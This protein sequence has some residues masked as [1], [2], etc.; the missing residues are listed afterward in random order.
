MRRVVECGAF[1]LKAMRR[2]PRSRSAGGSLAGAQNL[3]I[4]LLVVLII[5]TSANL[6]LDHFSPGAKPAA[7]VKPPAETSQAARTA[8]VETPPARDTVK[9]AQAST[10]IPAVNLPA[11]VPLLTDDMPAPR[12]IHIQILNG[13]GTPG[14][15]SRVRG[16][17][18]Q[19]GFDVLTFGNAKSQDFS[20]TRVIA[21][22]EDPSSL[23]AA[24][25]VASSLNISADRVSVEPDSKLVD[26]NVTLI[27][28]ADH[29][30]M[31][32]TSE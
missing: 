15:A 9:V 3:I 18:R 11:P 32:L 8:V 30:E 10:V 16:V 29:N 7:P 25:R 22:T 4:L 13:C 23:L 20:Q 1:L 14:I 21:R 2:R 31:D 5:L 24:R 19:R 17:L 6:Y 28:G 27:L 26:T 12:D